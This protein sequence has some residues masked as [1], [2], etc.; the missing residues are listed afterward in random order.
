MGSTLDLMNAKGVPLAQIYAYLVAHTTLQPALGELVEKGWMDL[1]R[2][3]VVGVSTSG[4][5]VWVLDSA[6]RRMVT[7][8]YAFASYHDI[9]Q[10]NYMT[11][12]SLSSAN[13]RR[14]G[15]GNDT[16]IYIASRAVLN[17]T[18]LAGGALA[19]HDFSAGGA[20]VAGKKHYVER[21]EMFLDVC[22]ADWANGGTVIVQVTE[23]TNGTILA[24][25]VLSSF[26]PHAVVEFG[27]IA[28]AVNKKLQVTCLA[29]AQPL[30]VSRVALN[31]LY[32][33][34]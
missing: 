33:S 10:T 14:V 5:L 9:D 31:V 8:Q 18:A 3:G 21:A 12:N 20:A 13:L 25:A 32:R 24:Q 7:E 23:E 11:Y 16:A 27:E 29:G 19:A 28:T 26:G 1:I 22:A 30:T 2:A 6:G 17:P 4:Y 15:F 34:L